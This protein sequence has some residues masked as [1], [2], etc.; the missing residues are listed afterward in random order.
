MHISKI[1]LYNFKSFYSETEINFD[2]LPGL[3]RVS[4]QIGSGKTSIGEAIIFG[5]YGKVT[6]KTNPSLI[7]W[8]RKKGLVELWGE[9]R[10]RNLYI[11]REINSYGQS[12]MSVEVDGVPLVSSDKRGIQ[13]LLE[14]DYLDIPRASMELLC[15][16]SFNNFKSLSTLNAKDTKMFLDNVLGFEELTKYVEATKLVQREIQNKLTEH[17]AN[18]RA[19]RNQWERMNNYKFIEGDPQMIRQEIQNLQNEIKKLQECS[20]NS[21]EPLQK[22]V[23]EIQTQIQEVLALGKLKSKEIKFIQQGTCPTCGAPIDSSQ[24][25]VK[26]RERKILRDQYISLSARMSD[27]NKQISQIS[28]ELDKSMSEKLSRIKSQENDLIRI[29]EQSKMTGHNQ[30]EMDLLLEQ[31]QKLEK[32]SQ[33]CL[34]DLAEYDQLNHIFQVQIRQQILDS[35]IPSINQKILEI[36]N[37]LELQFIPQFDQTFH[38]SIVSGDR[39]IPISAL[40]TGQLKMVD[41][42]IILAVLNSVVSMSKSN[43]IF[44]DELF[45]NLDPQT[46]SSLI[47]VLRLMLPAH[48]SVLIISHQDMDTD[49]FDGHIRMKLKSL[50]EGNFEE[51]ELSINPKESL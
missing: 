23:P 44:L 8:G 24:L 14:S 27:L 15:V 48:S 1:R 33:G 31:I 12:P 18:I 20:K 40:S 47:S 46:R 16:I 6:D 19:I 22:Q 41:M 10:G 30:A 45:S 5:L 25:D 51:T 29:Q 32:Y 34:D 49:L 9:A 3:W 36:T 2:D 7:S 21:L 37:I 11:R 38:C 13:D 42:V 43:V 17:Q 50:P 26:E 35:F 28:S 4:G 39:T